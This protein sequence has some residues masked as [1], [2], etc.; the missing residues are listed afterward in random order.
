MWE[1]ADKAAN[2]ASS[3]MEMVAST[4]SAAMAEIC[5][6]TSSVPHPKNVCNST[7]LW[8]SRFSSSATGWMSFSVSALAAA[9]TVGSLT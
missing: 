1:K 2:G 4:P 5:T 8:S 7:K 3:P 6:S 9:F